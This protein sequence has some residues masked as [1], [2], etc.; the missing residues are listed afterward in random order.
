MYVKA[1]VFYVCIC[2]CTHRHANTCVKGLCN[3]DV[4]H[5]GSYVEQREC[6]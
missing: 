1:L 3:C 6:H 4:V 5:S 2:M